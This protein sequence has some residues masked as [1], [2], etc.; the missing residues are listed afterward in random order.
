MVLPTIILLTLSQEGYL[1]VVDVSLAEGAVVDA[2]SWV[3][4]TRPRLAIKGADNAGFSPLH[5]ALNNGHAA[6]VR[7]P[8]Y[9]GADVDQKAS[10]G[11]RPRHCL[12]PSPA[13]SAEAH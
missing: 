13:G 1:V 9:G 2:A 11:K 6:T 5:C 8:L 7:A 10:N 12:S 3:G 4:E